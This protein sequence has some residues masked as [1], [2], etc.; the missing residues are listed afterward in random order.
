MSVTE[1]ISCAS[2]RPHRMYEHCVLHVSTFII[3]K[4]VGKDGRGVAKEKDRGSKEIKGRR[5]KKCR[6]VNV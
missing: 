2:P 6:I 3:G 5:G 1:Y 4:G